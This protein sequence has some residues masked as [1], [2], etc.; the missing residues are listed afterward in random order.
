MVG[1]TIE[2]L[3]QRKDRMFSQ[4]VILDAGL[5]ICIIIQESIAKRDFVA[6]FAEFYFFHLLPIFLGI[7]AFLYP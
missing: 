6:I 7:L 3:N 4:P 1:G 5:S 2:P